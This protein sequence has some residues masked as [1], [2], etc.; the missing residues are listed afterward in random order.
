MIAL[1]PMQAQA[2][3]N[4]TKDSDAHK[5]I[6]K[7]APIQLSTRVAERHGQMRR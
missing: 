2:Q 7:D 5:E 1:A 3:P 6:H 4:E